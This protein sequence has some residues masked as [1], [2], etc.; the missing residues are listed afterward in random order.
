M[1]TA[2]NTF[3]LCILL[4]AT[5]AF[6]RGA[7]PWEAEYGRLLA[8]YVTPAGTVKYKAWKANAADLAS[9]Q[10]ITDQIGSGGPSDTSRDGRFAFHINAYNAWMLRTVLEAYPIKSVRDIAPDFGVFSQPR[11]TVGG[12]KVSLNHLEKNLLLPEFK[13]PRIHVAINCAS[14]S[15]PPLLNVPF[16][17]AKLGAQLDAQAK[18]FANGSGAQ[19]SGK[20]A[21]LSK[22]FEWYAADFKAS[23]DA[24]GFLNKYR[25]EP[26]PG[27]AKLSYSEYD[28]SLNDAKQ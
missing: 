8:Q 16:T 28:W 24:T 14:T 26:I 23:G 12:K 22:I 4:L 20:K 17:A 7:E 5:A 6:S 21:Q 9:L 19:V 15:C 3:L 13:D 27:G 2:T 1:K 10:K 25:S 18:A 11:I